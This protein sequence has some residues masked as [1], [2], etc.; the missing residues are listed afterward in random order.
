MKNYHVI[1]KNDLMVHHES[2]TCPCN[3][4]AD[5]LYDNVL[6]H[7]AFDGRDIKEEL[8]VNKCPPHKWDK[9]GEKCLIC[10]DKDWMD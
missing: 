9:S 8:A 7:N 3:P 10:G 4:R 5:S 2:L 1:P 6:I